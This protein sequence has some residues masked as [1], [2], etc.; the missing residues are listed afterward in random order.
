MNSELRWW[1]EVNG[2]EG[3]L[4]VGRPSHMYRQPRASQSLGS[5]NSYG[6]FAHCESKDISMNTG[7]KSCP[8]CAQPHNNTS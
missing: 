6:Q 7:T 2:V 1:V 4:R 8:S 3:V 5:E